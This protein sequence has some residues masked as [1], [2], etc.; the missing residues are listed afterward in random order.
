MQTFQSLLEQFENKITYPELF[1][2]MP[3]NLYNPCRYL[4]SLGGKRIRP[5]ACLMAT[6]LFGNDISTSAW[7]AAI[8][9][10]LFHNF[11]LIHDDIMDKAPLRRGMP[12]IHAKYGMT[13]GILG[14]DA[15]S[16]YAYQSL[17]KVEI[18]FKLVIDIFNTTAIEV[19]EGQQL[20]MDFE[21]R[22][23]VGI[24]EYIDMIR[25][26]T[27]V[28]LAAS[29][30]I[31]ALIANTSSENCENIYNY[32]KYLGVAFQL[33]DDFLDA[34]GESGKLGKQ[35]G[36]DIIAN[37]KTFLHIQ[38]LKN[39]NSQQLDEI[40]YWQ[41]QND[42]KEKVPSM[43]RLFEETNAH[44][45]CRE[46]VLYYSKKAFDCLDKIPIEN[47]NKEALYSLGKMLLNRDK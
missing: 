9:I 28:L 6:E 8:A 2:E 25:L 41:S 22:E 40:K 43:L 10:E 30:K 19:C 33:Q 1:P 3:Q 16:I 37:K 21:Q 26:K 18:N 31:G 44:T 45:L 38:A 46:K 35:K 36:G 13:A 4:I 29:M 27:S 32:G 14:G 42:N 7:N 11:T 15:M 23:D 5:I 24:D 34:F 20:D 17:A 39:A 12:T 47:K